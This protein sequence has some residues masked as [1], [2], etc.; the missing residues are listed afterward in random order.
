MGPADL[1]VRSPSSN[2]ARHR[3]P[4]PDCEQSLDSG[5]GEGDAVSAIR[6]I[7]NGIYLVYAKV[8]HRLSWWSWNVN[9]G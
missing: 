3:L 7:G 6:F 2:D 1:R 8:C 4:G 9:G 5:N